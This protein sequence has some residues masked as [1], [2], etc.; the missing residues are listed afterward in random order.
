M[1]KRAI[2][3]ISTPAGRIYR[4]RY[5]RFLVEF[6]RHLFLP[7][8]VTFLLL[9]L[10]DAV[11]PESVSRYINLNYWLIAV[12]VTGI[13]AVLSGTETGTERNESRSIRGDI[14]PIICFGV[15]GAAVVWY[16]TRDL[17][18]LS[19]V[20]SPVAGILIVLLTLIIW[21]GPDEEESE[22]ENSPDN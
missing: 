5:C 2:D 19:Y 1:M 4:N 14:I 22:S 6:L 10:I 18:W 17:G 20:I 11:F 16:Q 15:V 9:L 3:K 12:I 21:Q 8:L 7:A 13:I